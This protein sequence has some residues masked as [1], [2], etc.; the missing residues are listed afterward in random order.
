MCGE[1]DEFRQFEF[2]VFNY[3]VFEIRKTALE[4]IKI[5]TKYKYF[6]WWQPKGFVSQCENLSEFDKTYNE[7]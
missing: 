2:Y 5:K 3:S 6:T 4:E 7:H 1:R